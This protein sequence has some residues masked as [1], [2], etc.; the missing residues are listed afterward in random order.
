MDKGKRAPNYKSP[1]NSFSYTPEEKSFRLVVLYS[2]PN[3]TLRERQLKWCLFKQTVAFFFTLV[4]F[5]VLLRLTFIIIAQPFPMFVR[6][7]AI[8]TILWMIR[9]L[10]KLL[11][12]VVR[13]Q[14]PSS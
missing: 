8:L 6:G 14:F 7:S 12:Y 2:R 10:L 3:S 4:L 1:D 9:E 5:C 11:T 13:E